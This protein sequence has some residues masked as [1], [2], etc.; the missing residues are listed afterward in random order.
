MARVLSRPG[1][2]ARRIVLEGH[3]D[4]IGSTRYN[5]TLSRRRAEAVARE[6]IARGIRRDRITV[7]AFGETRPV[8]PNRRANGSDDP[9][10]RAKNRRVEAV[11]RS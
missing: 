9:H 3:A 4:D 10:G 5:L 7:V 11:I 1:A 6:L 2:F 8:V